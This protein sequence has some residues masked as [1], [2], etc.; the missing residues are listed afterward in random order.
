MEICYL[1]K[2]PFLLSNHGHDA[3]LGGSRKTQ[4]QMLRLSNWD[5]IKISFPYRWTEG[6]KSVASNSDYW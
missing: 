5:L 1:T 6:S 3:N 4:M 2:N